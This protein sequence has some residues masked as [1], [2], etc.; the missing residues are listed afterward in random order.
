MGRGG[1]MKTKQTN[2]LKGDLAFARRQPRHE[3]L[4]L[5]GRAFAQ[6]LE[7]PEADAPALAEAIGTLGRNGF[8]AAERAEATYPPGE[9]LAAMQAEAAK[10][11]DL[12]AVHL[13]P[14]KIP[15]KA[16]AA[17]FLRKLTGR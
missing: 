16:K 2:R 9:R 15:L 8:Y 17:R 13:A 14:I 5:R 11:P 3:R 6:F 7:I 10:V 1:S 4:E 12:E